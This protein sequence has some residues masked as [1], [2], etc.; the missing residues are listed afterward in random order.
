MTR[1]ELNGKESHL[2]RCVCQYRLLVIVFL[3]ESFEC[4]SELPRCFFEG[5]RKFPGGNETVVTNRSKMIYL[6]NSSR[7]R[8]RVDSL[9]TSW[10]SESTRSIFP[11]RWMSVSLAEKGATH[12]PENRRRVIR[13]WRPSSKVMIDPESKTLLVAFR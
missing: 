5:L 6:A 12:L 11:L 8:R 9:L 1:K 4:L 13:F 2:S 3:I 7:R 10:S